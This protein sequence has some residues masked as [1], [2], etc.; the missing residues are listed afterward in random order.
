MKSRMVCVA[1]LRFDQDTRNSLESEV[2]A[3]S[4]G[5]PVFGGDFNA[6]PPSDGGESLA[7]TTLLGLGFTD[8]FRSLHPHVAEHP[9]HTRRCGSRID[10]L[11]PTG[12]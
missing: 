11:F 3:E 6:I 1:H 2:R 8:A 4:T 12:R 5:E 9:G 7:V 10:Q